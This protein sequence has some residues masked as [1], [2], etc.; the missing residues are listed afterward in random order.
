MNEHERATIIGA[1]RDVD[2]VYIYDNPNQSDALAMFVANTFV[3]GEQFGS[4][5]VSEHQLALSY[6][7]DQGIA[8]VR[9]PRYPNVS[10]SE[11][12]T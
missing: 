8:V 2:E 12:K 9:V 1:L 7:L 6:C 11:Y 3:I 10:S 4:Q 5:G